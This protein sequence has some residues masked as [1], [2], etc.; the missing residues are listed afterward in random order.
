MGGSMRVQNAEQTAFLSYEWPKKKKTFKG[1]A[2]EAFAWYNQNSPLLRFCIYM[3]YTTLG[4]NQSQFVDKNNRL[5]EEFDTIKA[6]FWSCV[7]AKGCNF[8]PYSYYYHNSIKV[9]PHFFLLKTENDNHH[10]KV[11]GVNHLKPN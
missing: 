5:S 11:F 4:F 3:P 9:L 8:A 7:I 6:I 1:E 2:V 10:Q